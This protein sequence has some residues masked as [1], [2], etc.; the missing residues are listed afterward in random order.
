MP[1]KLEQYE[2][3]SLKIYQLG[4]YDIYISATDH[5]VSLASGLSDV[6]PHDAVVLI[7]FEVSKSQII[8]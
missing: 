2:I 5:R 1:S 4:R 7:D 3:R 8:S 6:T